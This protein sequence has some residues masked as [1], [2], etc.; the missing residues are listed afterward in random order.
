MIENNP[1]YRHEID[2]LRAIAVLAVVLFHFQIAGFSGG[3]VGVDIFFVVSGYLITRNIVSDIARN[4]FSFGGFYTR[5]VRRLL[6]SYLAVALATLLAAFVIASPKIFV[7]TAR[8]AVWATLFS[9]NIMF[10]SQS[11]YFDADK[12]VK[13]LLHTWSLG[14]EEQFYLFWPLLIF[15]GMRYLGRRVTIMLLIFCTCAS[16]ALAIAWL[17]AS[18]VWIPVRGT[19]FAKMTDVFFL[20]PYRVWELAVG[21]LCAFFP[22]AWARRFGIR[23]RSGALWG[24][25]SVIGY[26]VIRYQP[27][28]TFPGIAALP[29]VLAAATIILAARGTAFEALGSLAPVRYLGQLSYTLYLVHWPVV[30]YWRLVTFEKPSGLSAAT[31]IVL[32]VGLAELLSKYVEVPFREGRYATPSGLRASGWAFVGSMSLLVMGL[33]G[34]VIRFDGFPARMLAEGSSSA[35]APAVIRSVSS[36]TRDNPTLLFNG[37][38]GQVG[39]KI[40]ETN[41]DLPPRRALVI[42]DSHAAHWADAFDRIRHRARHNF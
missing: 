25:C 18:T 34:S 23:L 40:Q 41:A 42:G 27:D 10:W 2:G 26:C 24:A 21:G 14:I 19:V 6:P 28:M 29:P 36:L 8:S 11:G 12:Y 17:S 30:V 9:S 4:R 5:R 31:L 32:S 38:A 7:E 39:A 16:L 15:A 33:A 13:P 22:D 35:I 3:F 37:Q 1:K 20:L